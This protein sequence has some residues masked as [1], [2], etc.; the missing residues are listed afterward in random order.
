MP[1]SGYQL[2][3]LVK[4]KIK[5]KL[6]LLVDHIWI[7]QGPQQSGSLGACRLAALT[8]DRLPSSVAN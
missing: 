5:E 7:R 3:L 8:T 4:L 2:E 6:R 1:G